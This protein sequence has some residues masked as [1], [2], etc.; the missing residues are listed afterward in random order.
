MA[1]NQLSKMYEIVFTY[2]VKQD[3]KKWKDFEISIRFI[4]KN[5]LEVN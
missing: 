4:E 5:I 2:L 1:K 3:D